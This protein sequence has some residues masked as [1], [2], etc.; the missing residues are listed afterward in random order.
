MHHFG[1]LVTR[2]VRIHLSVLLGYVVVVCVLNWPLL[3]H[4]N[5]HVIG[6]RSDDVYEV[7]WQLSWM[8]SA[9]FEARAFPFYCPDIFYPKGWYMASGA[10]PSWYLLALSGFSYLLG[11]ITAYN[12]ALLSTFVVA[13]FGV[14]LLVHHLTRNRVASLVAGCVYIAAPVLTLRLRG[15]L[16]ILLGAQ[17]LP[18]AMLFTVLAHEER[19][20]TKLWAAL[21]G[22]ALALAIL[23]HWYFLF[24]ATLPVIAM[25]LMIG[26]NWSW[27]R[28]LN[29]GILIGVVCILIVSPFAYLTFRARVEMFGENMR[30]GL[31]ESDPFSLSIDR[32]FAPN[33][34]HPLW[35]QASQRVFPLTGE[36][37]VVS[38]G[39]VAMIL[40]LLGTCKLPKDRTRPFVSVA[41]L[42]LILAMGTTLYWNSQRVEVPVPRLVEQ[43]YQSLGLGISLANGHIPIPLPGLLLAKLLPFYDAMRVWARFDIVFMLSVAVLAGFGGYY[44]LKK[45]LSDGVMLSLGLII[46]AEGFVAPYV[47]AYVP[48]RRDFAPVSVNARR[49]VTRWLQSQP[50]G[51]A[52]IEYPR[53]SVDRMAMYSQSLHGQ[54]IVNGYMAQRPSYLRDVD[55]ELGVWPNQSALPIL[56]DWGVDY[57]LVSGTFQ[58]E[59]QRTLSGIHTLAGLSH[60]R[61]FNEGFM[62]FTETHVFGVL[63]E[64]EVRV[65]GD[66]LSLRE[67]FYDWEHPVDSRSFCWTG[68]DALI[69][70][71][72][73]DSDPL[74]LADFCLVMGLAGGRYPEAE[75]CHLIVEA[76]GVTLFEGELPQDPS[77]R[78]LELAAES[79]QNVGLKDLEVRIR[80]N[81]WVPD[82]IDGRGDRRNLG[83]MFYDAR[84]RPSSEDCGFVPQ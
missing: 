42:S 33:P 31:A 55:A 15:H 71:P 53:P 54:S 48:T 82:D 36:Q 11:V 60:V 51:T 34:F 30:F 84:L 17:C 77:P 41:A 8:K 25:F 39:Y 40:A 32:L 28:R 74:A 20:S 80:T 78:L 19:K 38:I 9:V 37:D 3:L 7:L 13:G 21:A 72:W 81:T 43:V 57:V 24:I 70:F 61:S 45:G 63:Q 12:V 68:R 29:T 49:N 14:Y 59:F 27:R 47:N 83:C 69:A 22:C 44:L 50:K 58:P 66:Y 75:P 62:G 64:D 10:Q 5:S 4:I 46:L 16:N 18:Y 23:G 1:S 6:K 52:I 35:G 76:E 2:R 65:S 67:G 56:R 73:P 26:P 79:I